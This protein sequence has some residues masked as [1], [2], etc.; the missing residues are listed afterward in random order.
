M[1]YAVVKNSTTKSSKRDDPRFYL[2]RKFNK[3]KYGEIKWCPLSKMADTPSSTINPSKEPNKI[4]KYIDL[5]DIDEVE[6]EIIQ[7]HERKGS[8]IK[9]NK[10]LI[11]SGDLVFARIEPSIFNRKY[12]YFIS[13]I[14]NKTE[15]IKE[16]YLFDNDICIGSTELFVARP[17]TDVSTV[18]LHWAL[19][20]E[21]ISEQLNPGLLT[22]STGR[23]RLSKDDFS[24]L[25]I[26]DISVET[27]KELEKM[28]LDSRAKRSDYLNKADTIITETDA[29]IHKRLY[30]KEPQPKES[31]KLS[32]NQITLF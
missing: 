16:N 2:P 8:D 14:K 28:I 12:A 17:K 4:Y 32:N 24:N 30:Y 21:W 7:Y 6:G 15:S 26:P 18:Y 13:D 19:R 23:R 31:E 25:L 20:G 10:R 11:L 27:Q 5:A 9:G 3:K 1:R 22:G 29:E